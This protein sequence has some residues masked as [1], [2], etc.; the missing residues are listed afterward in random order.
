M[1][2]AE[3]FGRFGRIRFDE[4]GIRLR[5]YHRNIVQLAL[6]AADHTKRLAEVHLGMARRVRQRHEDLPIWRFFTRT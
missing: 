3:S 4:E 5:H 6:H 1:P 2:V